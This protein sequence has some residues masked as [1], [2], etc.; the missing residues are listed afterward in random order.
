MAIIRL[1]C[2]QCGGTIILDDSHRIGTCENCF[3][4]FLIEPDQIT[5]HVTKFV[6]GGSGEKDI[7]ELLEDGYK[8]QK[9]G[10]Y[11]EAN[12]KF[13]KAIKQKPDSW[14]AWFGYACTGGARNGW[15]SQLPAFEKAYCLAD[16][17]EKESDTYVNLVRYIENTELRAVFIRAFNLA[18]P[19][20]QNHIF[21]QVLN[22]IGCDESEI[23][24]LAVDLSPNDW[25][26]Q[27]AMAKIR[28]IRVRWCKLEGNFFVGKSLPPHAIEVLNLFLNAY[29]LAEEEGEYAKQ[30]IC[31]YIKD[32]EMDT[33][34]QV[35]VNELKK[36]L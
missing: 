7:E 29:R 16:T 26:A 34:Y 4:Q 5:Q 10:S 22:V 19:R 13:N 33:S 36:R 15:L 8:L 24:K 27:F 18:S 3:S 23:A 6:Y 9:L 21:S 28:Q 1:T 32:M 17:E 30:E 2:D 20:E 14:N 12:E 31:N 11:Q 35:F 25:R